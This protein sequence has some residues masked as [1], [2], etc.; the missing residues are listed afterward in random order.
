LNL[1]ASD[2]IEVDGQ[3][4][5]FA[6]KVNLLFSMNMSTG[7]I[8][9]LGSIPE[10][11]VWAS[12]LT[13]KLIYWERKIIIVPLMAKKIW[14]YSLESRKWTDV[15]FKNHAI[16]MSATYFRQAIIYYNSLFLIGGH[17]PAILE[18]D[19]NSYKISYIEAPFV[20]RRQ[21]GSRSEL[22]F[23]GDFACR[24]ETLYFASGRDNSV[25]IFHLDTKEYEWIEV[26]GKL[27]RYS[28]IMWDGR[29][30]WFSP[31]MNTPV[32]KW[33]GKD[34]VVEYE[35][36]SEKRVDNI[37]Y[38]GVVRR[39]NQI[40]MPAVSGSGADTIV[41]TENEEMEFENAT[42]VF[43]K[44]TED[45][46]YIAQNS[47]GKVIYINYGDKKKEFDC[48]ITVAMF[49]SV[50][51]SAQIDREDMRLQ[52]SKENDPFLLQEILKLWDKTYFRSIA[53]GWNIGGV[54]WE[55]IKRG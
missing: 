42:Y 41:I 46:K 35:I 7:S 44:N 25:L 28:G 37:S 12:R 13:C 36:P 14:I 21:Y 32:V 50:L 18:M 17:Y 2:A 3:L 40:V 38:L 52:I 27:N 8:S 43:Y 51:D 26:G 31:R 9:L 22:Y 11:S 16:D 24:G 10:E 55:R 5:L 29:H 45:G 15:E 53:E 6:E 34:K 47:E 19:L 39:G 1:L 33:D 49:C 4:I 30:Y 48:G 20:C 23:R 54:I